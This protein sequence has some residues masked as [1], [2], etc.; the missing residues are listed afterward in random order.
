[1]P[2]RTEKLRG[3]L[4]RLRNEHGVGVLHPVGGSANNRLS[5][6]RC[7]NFSESYC[8]DKLLENCI[9]YSSSIGCYW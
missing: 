9:M 7:R 8:L 3:R 6:V 4:I 5:V 1:M 2:P